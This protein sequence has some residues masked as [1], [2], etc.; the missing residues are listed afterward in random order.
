MTPTNE[1]HR[2][3]QTRLDDLDLLLEEDV[4]ELQP[5]VL[6]SLRYMTKDLPNL[7]ITIYELRI[8]DTARIVAALTTA[9]NSW[10]LFRS[11]AV[12]SEDGDPILVIL[13]NNERYLKR[14]IGTPIELQNVDSLT[15]LRI[16]G[17]HRKGELPRGLL[18]RATILKIIDTDVCAVAFCWDHV[19]MD[20]V[21]LT[22]WLQ[23]FEACLMRRSVGEMV[24]YSLFS[25][26][27]RTNVQSLVAREASAFH[28]KRLQGISTLKSSLWPPV[29]S[30]KNEDVLPNSG[31]GAIERSLEAVE[32][33]TVFSHLR[34]RRIP[35]M[36]KF[37]AQHGIRP[38]VI[39]KA[40][41]AIVNCIATET[42][43]AML[44]QL[45][46]G[47]S[48]PFVNDEMASKLPDP[49]K[50]AGP[51]LASAVDIVRIGKGETVGR[52]LQRLQ[53]DQ[54]LLNRFV[55]CPPVLPSLLDS[56][57][58]ATL[59]ASRRQVF[60]WLPFGSHKYL[61][62]DPESVLKLLENR[63]YHVD[64]RRFEL[65]W[66]CRLVDEE[67]QLSV[68][69]IQP[70]EIFSPSQI[71]GIVDQLFQVIQELCNG[72]NFDK[73]VDDII[74]GAARV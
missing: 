13:R 36:P 23:S 45:L 25:E 41:I 24:P 20:A 2:R 3:I 17:N 70:V 47:R 16:P 53:S 9:L 12:D 73:T 51:T 46:S 30:L 27:Y 4:M 40:A 11:I 14:A 5:V 66:R 57:D 35:M 10:P 58:Y 61:Q 50:L 37:G 64:E 49:Y 34:L 48:W 29:N 31:E 65:T 21:T 52:F 72:D 42:R 67:D 18:F 69:A 39:V 44:L 68:E 22:Q 56:E 33:H 54:K 15:S 55:H 8:K 43:V 62:T 60:N 19:V 7:R 6:P 38:S 59:L 1:L 63:T 32:T 74:D 26:V 71:S 28:I